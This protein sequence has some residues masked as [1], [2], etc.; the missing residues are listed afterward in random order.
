MKLRLALLQILALVT[1]GLFSCSKPEDEKQYDTGVLNL[2]LTDAPGNFDAVNIDIQ[3]VKIKMV[4]QAEIILTPN[5]VGVYNLLQFHNGIDTLLLNASVPT[6]TV[7]KIQLGLGTNNSVVINGVKYPLNTLSAQDGIVKLKFDADILANA[8]YKIWLDFDA[9]QSIIPNGA[10]YRLRPVIRGYDASEN[11]RIEGNV[12]PPKALAAVYA[13][14]GTDTATAIPT[15]VTGHFSIGGLEAGSYKVVFAPDT[16]G[17]TPKTMN[18][19]VNK[20]NITN[21]GNITLTP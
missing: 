14:K 2:Y 15:L 11:G 16:A 20:G 1:I 9:G 13:I 5:Q 18:V 12:L 6:G 21:T 3:L 19:N 7:E 17:Y 4:G 10:G 8:N